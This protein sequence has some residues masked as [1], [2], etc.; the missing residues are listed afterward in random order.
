MILRTVC[1]WLHSSPS[2]PTSLPADGDRVKY[3]VNGKVANEGAGANPSRG[4]IL[5]QS[6]GAEA[7][8]R[9]IELRLK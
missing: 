7:F 5:F 4:K 9:N 3:V 8:F 1:S 6:E 2:A